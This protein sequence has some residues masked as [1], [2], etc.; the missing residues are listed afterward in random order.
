MTFSL[1]SFI[2]CLKWKEPWF[3]HAKQNYYLNSSLRYSDE[4]QCSDHTNG[5]MML[6]QVLKDV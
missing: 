1:T 5:H 2:L 3:R 4:L 6:F